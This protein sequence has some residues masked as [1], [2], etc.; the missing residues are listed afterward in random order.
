MAVNGDETS[1]TASASPL[2]SDG[3]RSTTPELTLASHSTDLAHHK[4]T[5]TSAPC[6]IKVSD[7]RSN[8]HRNVDRQ[9]PREQLDRR[10]FMTQ[11]TTTEAC[12][13]S[14]R[15][16]PVWVKLD[17]QDRLSSQ[18]GAAA[19][20]ESGLVDVD[21]LNTSQTNVED[22]LVSSLRAEVS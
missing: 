7:G 12:D 22:C 10:T 19:S 15:R 6:P 17:D 18:T 13:L 14:R 4:P 3:A 21:D 20:G 5:A 8:I 2:S 9:G 16:S 11:Q 1:S